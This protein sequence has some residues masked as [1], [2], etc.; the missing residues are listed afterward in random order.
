M[1]LVPL[2]ERD[3]DW[4]ER[5]GSYS[6]LLVHLRFPLEKPPSGTPNHA[7]CMVIKSHGQQNNRPVDFT[8]DF[9]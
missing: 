6:A 8:Y 5:G 1:I 4:L 9:L 2:Q 7:F 3:E